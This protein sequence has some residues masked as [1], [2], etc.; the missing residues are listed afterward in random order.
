M[1]TLIAPAARTNYFGAAGA[2]YTSSFDR[3]ITATDAA[4]IAT[5]KRDGCI[6]LSD[7]LDDSGG[8]T[9]ASVNLTAVTVATIGAATTA[10]RV[11]YCSDGAAGGP[12]LAVANGTNWLRV[13]LG[14]A[15]A[16]A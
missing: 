12:C 16:V 11:V 15:V 1:A 3:L 14:A 7:I 6:A 5:L 8:F 4:D 13:A 2:V 10:G 9:M